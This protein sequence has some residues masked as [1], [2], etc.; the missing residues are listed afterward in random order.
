MVQRQ[1]RNDADLAILVG[2]IVVGLGLAG[3]IGAAMGLLL[4]RRSARHEV[5]AYDPFENAPYDDEPLSNDELARIAQS[6]GEIAAGD[7]YSWDEGVG[8]QAIA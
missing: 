1:R 5:T 6:E 3:G 4:G 7:V 2:T 8:R